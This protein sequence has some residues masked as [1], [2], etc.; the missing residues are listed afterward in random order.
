MSK[1]IIII[2]LL[3]FYRDKVSVNETIEYPEYN[4][5]LR[6]RNGK[7]CELCIGRKTK[8][9]FVFTVIFIVFCSVVIYSFQ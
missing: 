2:L 9:M 5:N 1:F 3:I 6:S 4:N 8:Q 7:E